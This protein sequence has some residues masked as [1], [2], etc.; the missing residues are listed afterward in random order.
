MIKS[1]HLR[2][3]ISEEQYKRLKMV[4]IMEQTTTSTLIRGLLHSYLRDNLINN[5][6][7]NQ[8]I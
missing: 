1:R 8:N 6:K 5:E 4:L 3:R 2:I 7:L